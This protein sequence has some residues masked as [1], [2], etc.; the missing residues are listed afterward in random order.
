MEA[1]ILTHL[2]DD[3]SGGV[4]GVFAVASVREV[5]LSPIDDPPEDYRRVARVFAAQGLPV[6]RLSAGDSL[7]W[8]GTTARVV[9]PRAVSYTH[10]DVYKR[11]PWE[12]AP[13]PPRWREA[14]PG[15]GAVPGAV[16]PSSRGAPW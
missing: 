15:G 10:L 4:E 9:G 7:T 12:W 1:L 2:H 3:H 14:C 5:F 16:R 13:D 11:Q 6:Q 8:V